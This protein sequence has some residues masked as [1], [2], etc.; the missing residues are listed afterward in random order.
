M[1]DIFYSWRIKVNTVG[2]KDIHFVTTNIQDT[3]RMAISFNW[4]FGKETFARKRKANDN[5]A[6]DL[7]GESG[8]RWRERQEFCSGETDVSGCRFRL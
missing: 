3:R 1:E 7:K 6:D 8:N 5:G 4:S 2:L